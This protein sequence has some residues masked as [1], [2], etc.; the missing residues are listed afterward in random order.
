MTG[1]SERP[2]GRCCEAEA[3]GSHCNTERIFSI[4]G[5][6]AFIREWM[7]EKGELLLSL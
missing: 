7:R 2:S 5:L 1:V 6:L 4:F 3:G